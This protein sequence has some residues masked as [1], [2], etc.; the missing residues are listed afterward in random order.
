MLLFLGLLPLLNG[1]ADFLSVGLTRYLLRRSLTTSGPSQY[2]QWLWDLV[3]GLVILALLGSAIVTLGHWIRLA[4][5]QPILDVA[6]TLRGLETRPQD[7]RWLILGAATTL[8]PT[9][10]HALLLPLALGVT[11]ASRA[12]ATF[13]PEARVSMEREKPEPVFSRMLLNFMAF[14]AATAV[15][16]AL[17][18]A[19]NIVLNL[20]LAGDALLGFFRL[21]AIAAGVPGLQD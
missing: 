15:T 13:A 14:C 12:L 16:V 10:L 21:V 6:G 19:G 11:L 9:L 8:L 5:G 17:I 18:V 4:D 7:Y 20:P 3:G 1:I 2:W